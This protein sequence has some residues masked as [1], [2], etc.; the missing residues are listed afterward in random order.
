[1]I[2]GPGESTRP[3]PYTATTGRLPWS[4]PGGTN[5]PAMLTRRTRSLAPADH[6]DTPQAAVDGFGDAGGVAGAGVAGMGEGG[7]AVGGFVGAWEGGPL[8]DDEGVLPGDA[9]AVGATVGVAPGVPLVPGAVV[10]PGAA[11]QPS[12]TSAIR[13]AG[14]AL[15]GTRLA[16]GTWIMN[17]LAR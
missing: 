1:M 11:T 13:I 15:R 5:P 8:G 10:E 14:P 4:T 17:G 16:S 9:G 12:T 7:V 3:S 6:V 2:W